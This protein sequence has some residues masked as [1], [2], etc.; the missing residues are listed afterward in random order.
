MSVSV[1]LIL[2]YGYMYSNSMSV[3]PM[4]HVYCMDRCGYEHRSEGNALTWML[5][6][7]LLYLA[8]INSLSA[9]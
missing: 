5:C 2:L 4:C 8:L 1:T 7:R 3:W 6:Q 9:D